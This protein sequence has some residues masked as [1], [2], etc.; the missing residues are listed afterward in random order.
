MP[1]YRRAIVPGGTLFLTL[2]TF[3]RRPLFA[4]AANV[5]RL[6]QAIRDVQVAR[7]FT[8]DAGVV[9]PDHA[10]LLVTLPDGDDAYSARIGQVKLRFTQSLPADARP[11]TTSPSRSK[12]GEAAVWQRRFWE[13]VVRDDPERTRLLDYVHYNPVKHGYVTCPHAWPHSS[14]GRF[15]QRGF[16]EPDWCCCCDGRPV[17][18]PTFD[19][20]AA[21]VGE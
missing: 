2:V 15:V 18:P 17:R 3:D 6:R 13:H 8:V 10:H 11:Q 9:L 12:H 4:D 1:D 16:Y 21:V 5:N 20:L 19:G 7:P 14:F